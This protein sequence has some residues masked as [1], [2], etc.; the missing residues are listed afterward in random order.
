MFLI[1]KLLK[2]NNLGAFYK[3]VNNKLSSKSGIA[4]LKNKD[5]I[6]ITDDVEKADLLNDYFQSVFTTD[7]GTLPPFPSRLGFDNI[8]ISDITISPKIIEKILK[9]LKT[10]SAAGP[11]NLPSILFHHT[12]SAISYPLDLL[13][14]SLI[15]SRSLPSEWR[16]SII[17]PKLKKGS[18]SDPTNYRPIALT[19]C[20]CKI[21]ETVIASDILQFLSKHNLIT[22][23][24]HGFLKRHS[25]ST[26]LLESINDWTLT[27]SNHK[28]VTIA[29]LDFKA[30]F[31]CV[32][33][34][35]LIHKLSSYGIQDN[36]LFWIK[37][38]LSNRTQMVRINTSFSRICP[39]T[40]GIPQGSCLGPLLF[41][42]FINDIT[43]HLITPIKAKLFADDLKIYTDFSCNQNTLQYQLNQ[44]QHWS[45]TWQMK[46]SHSKCNILTIGH[47]R[48]PH[49]YFI[50]DNQISKADF[51]RDLGVTVDHELKF[52]IHINNIVQ[53]AN[54][55]AAQMFR[56]FLSRNPTTLIRAFK[57][58]IR[59]IL[60]Y[61]STTWS[62]SY[63]HQINLIE[64]VQRG[65]TRR[66]PGC[67]HL[68]YHERLTVLNLQTLEHRRLLAD[69]L[70]CFNIIKGNN[71]IEQ[72]D[73]F[74][75]PS[76]K[77]SRG[78]HLKLSIPLAKSNT[79]KFFFV[80]RVVPIWNSLPADIVITNSTRTFKQ[81]IAKVNFSKYLIFPS[82]T[83]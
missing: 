67:A 62:P 57:I 19:C 20:C 27:L 4:P 8:K 25:T 40:S 70:M 9:K 83:Q 60:E 58:Y 78:H 31:D 82:C 48:D 46:I 64:S 71:C 54:Q 3:F 14:R 73:F 52:K 68:S 17:T 36:L 24:Q 11:D 30:A 18:N 53:Q 29:Y 51:T 1:E 74:Q 72:A 63:I 7:D 49:Q 2:A 55:R 76:F 56:C 45:E 23:D 81:S 16:L 43:D 39:V 79:R 33:H 65:F 37:A 61:A 41:N 69:L 44:I 35:K 5:G 26:N 77:F 10:N 59:P 42:L 66:I 38:F 34:A 80:S 13:F 15:E 12:A 32:S 47:F 50:N 22:R 28:S 75:L 6:L 21:L